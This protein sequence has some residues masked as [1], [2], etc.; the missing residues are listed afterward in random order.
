MEQ[1]SG[2]SQPS[3]ME[4]SYKWNSGSTRCKDSFEF[5]FLHAGMIDYL[6]RFVKGTHDSL[7]LMIRSYF[8][9]HDDVKESEQ[10]SGVL[11]TDVLV[12]GSLCRHALGIFLEKLP[13]GPSIYS[14]LPLFLV[15]P[16]LKRKGEFSYLL[17][18]QFL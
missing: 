2:C 11:I 8:K 15:S 6:A 4:G 18:F 12:E 7:I 1:N 5:G 17:R 3:N 14:S 9:T 16:V 13:G 10:R